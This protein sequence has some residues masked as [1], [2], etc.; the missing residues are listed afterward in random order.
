[1]EDSGKTTYVC[2]FDLPPYD[3]KVARA[4]RRYADQYD[5][6]GVAALLNEAI[7]LL[8]A[9][10]REGARRPYAKEDFEHWA[11]SIGPDAGY[12]PSEQ[13]MQELCDMLIPVYCIPHGTGM[14][15]M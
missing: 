10:A 11:D 6:A 15:P 2:L 5:P 4:L 1:M 12:K 8:P 3:T 14:N 7:G 13:T 9:L